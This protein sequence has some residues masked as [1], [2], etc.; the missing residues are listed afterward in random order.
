MPLIARGFNTEEEGVCGPDTVTTYHPPCDGGEDVMDTSTSMC[1]SS[2]FVNGYGVV[3]KGDLNC[4]HDTPITSECPNLHQLELD[5]GS[6]SVFVNASED[7]PNR[8]IG[9]VGDWYGITGAAETITGTVQTTCYANRK[10]N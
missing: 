7:K 8:G 4:L 10:N 9:R 6:S 5:M 2:V 3:R 1:S